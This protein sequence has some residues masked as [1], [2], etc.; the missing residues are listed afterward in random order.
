MV[1]HGREQKTLFCAPSPPFPQCI[2][3]NFHGLPSSCRSAWQPTAELESLTGYQHQKAYPAGDHPVFKVVGP[4][5]KKKNNL[6]GLGNPQ[7]PCAVPAKKRGICF[8]YETPRGDSCENL[9][10]DRT[11]LLDTSCIYKSGVRKRLLIARCQDPKGQQIGMAS[12]Y[13]SGRSTMT[14]W[15]PCWFQLTFR[16][17]NI[18]MDNPP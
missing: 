9:A 5:K 10:N 4:S 8:T 13:E 16:Q 14:P 11:I 7:N 3:P 1:Y 12:E 6:G 18:A 17:S 15:V 2:G